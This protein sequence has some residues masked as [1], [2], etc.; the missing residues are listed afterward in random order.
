M[1]VIRLDII[2]FIL[3]VFIV[4]NYTQILHDKWQFSSV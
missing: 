1:N 4:P 3:G 2:V